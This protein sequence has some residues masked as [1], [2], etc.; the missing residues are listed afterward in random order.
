MSEANEMDESAYREWWPLHLRVARGE[1][2]AGAERVAYHAGLDTIHRAELPSEDSERLRK[3]RAAVAALE[4][5][6]VTLRERRD[7]LEAEI[8][9]LE[10]MLNPRD[11]NLL[12]ARD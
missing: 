7:Q 9:A 5:E 6:Q 10:S 2:L 4:A 8:A 1:V 11:R 12:I 3:A